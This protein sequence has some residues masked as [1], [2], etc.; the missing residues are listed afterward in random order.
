MSFRR[1]HIADYP[2]PAAKRDGSDACASRQPN[3]TDL[4]A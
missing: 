2:L 1:M 3:G 4:H